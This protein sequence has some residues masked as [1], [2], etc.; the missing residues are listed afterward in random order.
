VT[1]VE[2][3][4]ELMR[5]LLE[6]NLKLTMGG[7]GLAPCESGEASVLMTH[8]ILGDTLTKDQL[9]ASVSAIARA[10]DDIDD[11][12]VARFGGKTALDKLNDT[13]PPVRWE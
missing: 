9:Y 6:Y 4:E 7:F 8:T 10:A 11:Q 12:I 5:F 3:T 2:P 13:L 1:D